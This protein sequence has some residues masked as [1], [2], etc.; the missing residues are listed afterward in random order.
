VQPTLFSYNANDLVWARAG[1][2]GNQ[3][4]WPVRETSK[5]FTKSPKT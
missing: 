3:P 2:K 1:T 5:T 4:F